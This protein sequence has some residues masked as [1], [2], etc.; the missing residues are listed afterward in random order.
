MNKLIILLIVPLLFFVIAPASAQDGYYAAIEKSLMKGT[1]V[2]GVDTLNK[3][4]YR[5]DL[6][7]LDSLHAYLEME[8]AARMRLLCVGI[9]TGFTASADTVKDTVLV[10]ADSAGT[11]TKCISWQAVKQAFSGAVPTTLKFYVRVDSTGQLPTGGTAKYFALH[12]R[13]FPRNAGYSGSAYTIIDTTYMTGA[14]AD[15]LINTAPILKIP[16]R[17]DSMNVFVHYGDSCNWRLLASAVKYALDDTTDATLK[18]DTVLVA[19][20]IATKA[21]IKGITWQNIC[22]AFGGAPPPEIKFR[23]LID[24][25]KSALRSRDKWV[26]LLGKEYARK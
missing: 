11:G 8:T 14:V 20:G 5:L 1:D 26:A 22:A 10:W 25:D 3:T 21:G 12:I 17:I 13:E 15:L 9:K 4:G 23:L 18:G 6:S 16:W 24:K 2:A 19:S 7:G